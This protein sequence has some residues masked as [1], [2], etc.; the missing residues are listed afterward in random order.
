M[1]LMESDLV[2]AMLSCVE[3]SLN[4]TEV[5][6]ARGAAA[7]V[8][9]ASEGYPGPYRKGAEISGLDQASKVPG[10][11]VFQAGTAVD[12][13]RLV[14]SGGRVL[15]VAGRAAD[16]EGALEASYRAMGLISFQGMHFRTDIGRRDRRPAGI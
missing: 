13:G 15:G 6:W 1:P 11:T 9:A 16:L 2:E 12:N 8:I 3:G 7:C 4:R 14:T 10:V 5:R